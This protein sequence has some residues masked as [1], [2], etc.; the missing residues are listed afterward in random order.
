MYANFGHL[1]GYS[2]MY[3]TYMWSLV[4]AKDLFSGFDPDDMLNPETATEY[5]KKVLDP[6][7][8]RDASEL[9]QDFLGR[10]YNF[11]AFRNWLNRGAS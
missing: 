2:A 5:R 9:I 1:E 8:T 3:Y 10:E 7:G 6:G 11:E 4:I